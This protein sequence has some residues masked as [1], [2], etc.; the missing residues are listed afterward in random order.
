[1][2]DELTDLRLILDT[3][4]D[5]AKAWLIRRHI[6]VGRSMEQATRRVEDNDLPNTQLVQKRSRHADR[7]VRWPDS[8][9][10]D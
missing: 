10:A 1:V 3:P 6:A 5:R 4:P 2:I 8:A 7:V 9:Y